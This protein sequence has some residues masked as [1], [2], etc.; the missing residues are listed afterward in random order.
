MD[1]KVKVIKKFNNELGSALKNLKE[2]ERIHIKLEYDKSKVEESLSLAS[3][4][5]PSKIQEAVQ[6]VTQIVKCINDMKESCQSVSSSI[7]ERLQQENKTSE[8]QTIIDDISYL[9]RSSLYLQFVKFIED[10]STELEVSL[11]SGNDEA[12]IS[13]YVI[14]K[15]TSQNLDSSLC[16]NLKNYVDSTLNYWYT[17]IRKKLAGE[18]AEI[19]KALKWPFLGNN[20]TTTTTPSHETIARFKIVTEHLFH[21][22]LP[23]SMIKQPSV[24]LSASFPPVC[25]PVT[26]LALPLKQRFLYHF[27]GVKQTN[28]RDKPEWFL[29]Q[30]LTWIRDHFEWVEKMVQPIAH[31][32]G[33]D[34]VNVKVQFMRA[35][36]QLAVEKLNSE[37]AIVQFDDALFAHT[38]DEALGF[39]RELRESLF[40]PASEPATVFVLT[41]AQIF[42]KWITMEKKY[43]TERMDAILS[44]D[45]AW[46]RLPSFIKDDMK[47][48][49]CAD[50]FLTLLSTISDRYNHLPQPGHRLQFLDLQLELIDDWRVRLLQLLHEDYKDPLLSLMPS[51]LN[52]LHYVTIILQ[53]WG[54]SVPFLKL[55]F[56]K[57][58][59]EDA[60]V[61]MHEDDFTDSFIEDSEKEITVFDEV[62]SLLQRLE[63]KLMTEIGDFVFMEIKAKSRPYCNEK[64]FAMS[65]DKD[66]IPSVTPTGCPMFQEVA[67]RLNGLNNALALPLFEQSWISLA[68][69]LDQYLFDELVLRNQFNAGGAAQLQFDIKRNLFPLFGL[70]TNKSDSYFFLMGEACILLNMLV[71]SAMLLIEALEDEEENLNKEVLADVNIYQLSGR[72]ALK[73]LK[74]R[75]DI[76]TR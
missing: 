35:L 23:D 53:D 73:V 31:A 21:L 68:K 1:V 2:I 55:Y 49:E 41:Q 38:V 11:L 70:Y 25:L 24:G 39:E 26:L 8:L 75:M 28:R 61:I 34:K 37:L 15:E 5:A 9:E 51:I 59:F 56:F 65:F 54:V 18:Y 72:M 29:T 12:C 36:V 58:Q 50:A 20:L 71:G 7:E 6:E 27:T 19:L 66:T 60:E 40:Y 45:T 4:E 22:Q 44:S 3:S 46:A 17:E 32:A 14:L 52:T 69:R 13:S 30:T 76:S 62:I 42:V 48:T 63:N 33:F 10:L 47:V 67:N 16:K 64:W 43:A 74:S 57:K